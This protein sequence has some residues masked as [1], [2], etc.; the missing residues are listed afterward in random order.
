MG[1]SRNHGSKLTSGYFKL[2][3]II[4]LTNLFFS[5]TRR[6]LSLFKMFIHGESSP[7]CSLL[8]FYSFLKYQF[9]SS[10][11]YVNIYTNLNQT[12]FPLVWGM[13]CSWYSSLINLSALRHNFAFIHMCVC[14]SIKC[15]LLYI[16]ACNI[17]NSLWD[18]YKYC[19]RIY[20]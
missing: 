11:A 9:E 15:N 5:P 8:A 16:M 19:H 1:L 20:G 3:T 7:K 6:C 2:F 13:Q 14:A 18:Q 4:T 12:H 10:F 17:S